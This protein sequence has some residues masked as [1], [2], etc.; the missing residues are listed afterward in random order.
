M[1][2]SEH[3]V[4]LEAVGKQAFIF[5][6]CSDE[7]AHLGSAGTTFVACPARASPI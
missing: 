1:N 3:F 4:L 2:S 6:A 5:S 7:G